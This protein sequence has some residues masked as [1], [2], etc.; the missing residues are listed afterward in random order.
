MAVLLQYQ[1]ALIA[2]EGIVL[3][4]ACVLQF[5]RASGSRSA[6]ACLFTIVTTLCLVQV[7][8]VQLQRQVCC[9]FFTSAAVTI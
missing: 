6:L 2:I 8:I 4:A 3:A 9:A 1:W 7:V 5:L